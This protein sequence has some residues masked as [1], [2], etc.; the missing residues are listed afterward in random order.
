[1]KKKDIEQ[2]I[3]AYESAFQSNDSRGTGTSDRAAN[4]LVWMAKKAP[5]IPVSAR[6][7]A[8]VA[9][10]SRE[11]PVSSSDSTVRTIAN[12]VGWIRRILEGKGTSLHVNS[13]ERPILMRAGTDS[14]DHVLEYARKSEKIFVDLASRDRVAQNVK[15]SDLDTA[16]RKYFVRNQ[17]ASAPLVS[18][19]DEIRRMSPP[20]VV[21]QLT[22]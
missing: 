10:N 17:A 14:A 4:F 3:L 5:R 7:V 15:V 8:R 21:L 16:T 9:F 2:L 18:S 19:I 1:M 13:A 20:S 12:S 22:E 6:Y 11:T